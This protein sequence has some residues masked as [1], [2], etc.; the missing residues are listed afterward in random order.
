MTSFCMHYKKN[1]PGLLR[2][3]VHGEGEGFNGCKRGVKKGEDRLINT[4]WLGLS[5]ITLI[6]F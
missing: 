3:A 6:L 2:E 5:L 4:E 1:Q